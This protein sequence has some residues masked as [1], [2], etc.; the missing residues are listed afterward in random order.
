MKRRKVY[1]LVIIAF[2]ITISA[3]Y[4]IARLS[5]RVK[6]IPYSR[7]PQIQFKDVR[8]LIASEPKYAYQGFAGAEEKDFDKTLMFFPGITSGTVFTNADQGYGPVIKDLKIVFLDARMNVLK[9][10]ILRK[11]TGNSTAPPGTA[12]VIEGLYP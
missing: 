11:E 5:N 9:E 4:S 1:L 2:I 3:C 7:W 10:D 6:R 8:I 12:M